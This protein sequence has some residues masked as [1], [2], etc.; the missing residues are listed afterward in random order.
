[1]AEEHLM[2]YQILWEYSAL[3]PIQNSVKGFFGKSSFKFEPL[4]TPENSS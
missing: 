4:K 3:V 2:P 1:M